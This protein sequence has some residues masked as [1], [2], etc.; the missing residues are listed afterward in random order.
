MVRVF[1]NGPGDLGS[2]PAQVIPKTQKWYLMLPCLTLSI[3][4]YG[5]RVKW[6][7]L[8][9]G[10]APSPTPWCCNYRK[11]SLWVILDYGRQ[12]YLFIQTSAKIWIR[13]KVMGSWISSSSFGSIMLSKLNHIAYFY[14]SLNGRERWK[15]SMSLPKSNQISRMQDSNSACLTHFHNDYNSYALPATVKLRYPYT[16]PLR[17]DHDVTQRQ[18][19]KAE[20]K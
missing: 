12:L 4:R 2:I 6:S 5:S 1:A 7:N 17:H 3:I 15:G 11:G 16:Q 14:H 10:V 13:L 9:K 18:F 19:F 8:E 20:N